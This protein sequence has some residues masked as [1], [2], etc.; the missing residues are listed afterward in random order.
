LFVVFVFK[1]TPGVWEH[2]MPG[3]SLPELWLLEL[4]FKSIPDPLPLHNQ[5]LKLS[6]S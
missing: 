4:L 3:P 5:L 2:Q 1:S 6:P